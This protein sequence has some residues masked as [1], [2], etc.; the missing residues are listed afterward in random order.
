MIRP[1]RGWGERERIAIRGSQKNKRL[2]TWLANMYNNRLYA[3]PAQAVLVT[4]PVALI[5][6][7]LN[8][9]IRYNLGTY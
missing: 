7:E 4:T 2:H 5:I 9:K 1:T 6:C 8:G 3:A